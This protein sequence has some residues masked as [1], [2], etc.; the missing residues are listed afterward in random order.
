MESAIPKRGS[1]LHFLFV[2]LLQLIW[3]AVSQAQ[4]VLDGKFGTSGAITPVANNFDITAPLGKTVGNNLF[5]SFSQFDITAGQIATFSGPANIQNILTRIT[6]P[7]ASSIDGTIR[8]TIDGANLFFLNPHGVV[9]GQNAQLDVKG[10]FAVTTAHYIQLADGNRF[11]TVNPSANDPLLTSAPPNAFGFLGPTVA[12]ISFNGCSLSVPNQKSLSVIGGDIQI[13]NGQ[14]TAAGGRINIVSLGSAGTVVLDVNDLNAA[15][16]TSSFTTLGSLTMN[17]SIL[18]GDDQSSIGGGKVVVQAQELTFDGSGIEASSLGSENSL[19]VD[20]TVRDQMTLQNMSFVFSD[21]YST[22]TGNGG[23]I[24]IQ[25][26]QLQLLSGSAITCDVHG[27]GNG[28]N[29]GVS[30]DTIILDGQTDPNS[31]AGIGARTASSGNAGAVTLNAT[32]LDIRN[33]MIVSTVSAGSGNAG[34]STVSATGLNIDGH[35]ATSGIIADTTTGGGNAGDVTITTAS[36][37]ISD[38]G[39]ISSATGGAG[40]GGHIAITA[41]DSIVMDGAEGSLFTGVGVPPLAGATGNG[42]DL[43]INTA[44]LSIR[45]GARILAGT[46]G[47]G[48]GGNI[49]V[50]ATDILLDGGDATVF[51]GIQAQTAGTGNGGGITVNTSSLR[52]INGAEINVDTS[53]PGAGGAINIT[54][55]SVDIES[56]SQLSATSD[57]Q[58][59]GGEITMAADS[60]VVNGG[61]PDGSVGFAGIFAGNPFGVQG[62]ASAGD[63]VI[64]T[65]ASGKLS[66]QLLNGAEISAST[67]G[68]SDGGSIFVTAT[69]LTL[70]NHASIQCSTVGS[71]QA[72]NISLT[73]QDTLLLTDNSTIAVPAASQNGGN[74][75]INVGSQ[76]DLQDSTLNASAGKNGGNITLNAGSVSLLNSTFDAS[77]SENGGNITL[78][79]SSQASLHNSTLDATAGKNGGDITLTA[80]GSLIYLL[81]SSLTA[82]AGDNGGNIK[83]DPDFLVLDHSSITADAINN[84]GGNIDV[85]AKYFL[86]AD[87]SITA[88]SEF[89]NPGTVLVQAI[90]LD[91]S[92]DLVALPSS[93]LGA[94]SQLRERCGVR[95][96]GGFSSF[97]VLGRGGAP[98]EPNGPLPAFGLETVGGVAN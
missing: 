87:S 71:G 54:A 32:T 50:T 91:L 90:E 82:S 18:F 76:A 7:N 80:A 74:I 8:S 49:N 63:I 67:K 93:L 57:G 77:A 52:M 78:T 55:H 11:D 10:S 13:V 66:L 38:A 84:N 20:V 1:L 68:A 26:H 15:L 16:D 85:V 33:G 31:F 37:E 9:F 62:N 14:L 5:H 69:T 53:S 79:A 89:G 60:L 73:V 43:V 42:G 44:S 25:A 6:G 24:N 46:L 97:L 12:P 88:D 17:N 51:T 65:G 59:Q 29:I 48:D 22:S 23:N 40:N 92:G 39:R 47:S 72:G 95:A 96:A 28:G 3:L 81:D 30:A 86:S 56:S 41:T 94:E 35:G 27:T 4:I 83:V 70:N 61:R 36:L 45:N 2:L 21:E 19:G 75:V 34:N 98:I 58:G 64:G